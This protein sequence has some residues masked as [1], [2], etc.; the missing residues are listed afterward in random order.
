MFIACPHCHEL[1]A[2][3]P[4]S[5]QPP[6][7][8]PR[9][10]GALQMPA[11]DENTAPAMPVAPSFA[12]L[13]RGTEA[14]AAAPPPTQVAGSAI[15]PSAEVGPPVEE[16]TPPASTTDAPAAAASADT[17]SE[18]GTAPEATAASAPLSPAASAGML[19]DETALSSEPRASASVDAAT[20]AHGDEGT[21][22]SVIVAPVASQAAARSRGPSFV[23]SQRTTAVQTGTAK[24]PWWLLGALTLLLAI[25]VLL[26]DRARLA[27]DAGWRPLLMS[28][29]GV[30]RCSLPPWREPEAFVMLSRD[31]RPVAEA[32]GT[33][34]AQASFRNDARWPQPWP[35]LLLTLKDADGRTLGARALL[36]AEYLDASVDSSE[37]AAGQSAQVAVRIREPSANVVAY[38][39][40]FR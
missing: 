9:C 12:S 32:P 20:G 39:F 24:G 16:A 21:A 14:P 35:V 22:S 27:M 33:L 28:M 5:R 26:A 29:C 30:L 11:S 34:Q 31:V 15:E 3:H 40:D 7:L 2:P 4:Q 37:I 8:C 25:Q 38:S 19:A 10:G 6:E 17:E 18:A 36:P 13:L 23:R 1:V